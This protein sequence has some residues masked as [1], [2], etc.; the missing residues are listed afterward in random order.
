MMSVTV[1]TQ[2]TLTL[3]TAPQIHFEHT[4]V[5]QRQSARLYDITPD[6]DRFLV[7]ASAEVDQTVGTDP[8]TPQIIIVQN[9]FEE[10]KELVPVP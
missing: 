1:A 8:I 4:F 3:G 6:G 7:V 9:W 5:H 10:L 2:P